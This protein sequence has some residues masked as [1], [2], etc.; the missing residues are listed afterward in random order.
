MYRIDESL[1]C[2]PETNITL[3]ANYTGIKFL[4]IS[5]SSNSLIMKG[6]QIDTARPTFLN[7]SKEKIYRGLVLNEGDMVR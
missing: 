3:Y 4:K 7:M 1:Y 5:K 2:K 6:I